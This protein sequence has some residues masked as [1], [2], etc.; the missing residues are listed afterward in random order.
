MAR[1]RF[2]AGNWKMNTTRTEAL[3]LVELL[4]SA[5]ADFDAVDTAVCPP[6]VYLSDVADKL[7]GSNIGLGAQN[8]NDQDSGA[9]T[10]EVSANMLRDIGCRY[11]ILGHSERRHVYGE[12]DAFI[13]S[14]I[15]KALTEGLDV[16]FCVG[17]TLDERKADKTLDVVSQQITE[18]LKNVDEDQMDG[19]DIAARLTIAYEPVWAIGTGET[20]TPDQAQ[21]VH[22]AIRKLIGEMYDAQTA[23]DIRIQYGGSVKP[24]NAAELFAQTDID[25]GLIGGAS[26]KSKDFVDIIKAGL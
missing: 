12:T 26:L 15:I 23:E 4:R 5:L 3:E 14:K 6:Y 10:G 7:V 1:K 11:V 22:A 9:Y 20:A 18:G 13:N 8:C 25:G 24:G 17:E 19:M 2:V 21:D 16:I